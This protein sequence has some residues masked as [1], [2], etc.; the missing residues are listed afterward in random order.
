MSIVSHFLWRSESVRKT[1]V[2]LVERVI[3]VKNCLAWCLSEYLHAASDYGSFG[4]ADSEGPVMLMFLTDLSF[5]WFFMSP[6]DRL[7]MQNNNHND[8]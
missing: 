2:E 7:H 1:P 4:V 3:P 8:G 6:N 5:R